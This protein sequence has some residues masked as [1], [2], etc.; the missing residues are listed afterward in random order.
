MIYEEVNAIFQQKG[1][2]LLSTREDVQKAKGCVKFKYVAKC[3]HE[4]VVFY[5]V[6]K[7]RDTG[8]ICPNCVKLENA[9]KAKTEIQNDKT[10]LMKL[11]QKCIDY[12]KTTISD[13]FE[14]TRTFNGCRADMMLKPINVE[15]DEWIGIQVKSTAENNK[16]YGFHLDCKGYDNLLILCI[17][18]KDLRMWIIPFNIVAHITKL[19][20]GIKK[21]KYNIYEITRDNWKSKI[22]EYYH[23]TKKYPFQELDTPA[24]IYQVREKLYRQMRDNVIDFLQFSYTDIEGQ[25][26]DFMCEGL[27]VQEK[28]GSPH[29]KGYVFTLGK[30]NGSKDKK[31]QFVSYQ[32]GDNDIY[33]LNCN[34]KKH[35]FVIPETELIKKE[36]INKET[37]QSLYLTVHN[38]NTWYSKYLFDY[39]NVDKDKLENIFTD[40]HN[41]N[42]L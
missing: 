39:T 10:R 16:D 2:V 21:S 14:C 26:F 40:I 23:T 41:N 6:F 11:E 18:W 7:N 12:F 31:R 19:T 9:R 20:I 3:G 32:I 33:W 4:H 34:D 24:C 1:C 38:T 28:V 8:V 22:Y 13:T 5:N 27:K 30:N 42:N 37:K 17:C 25:V 15:T 29:K 36:K 35:F